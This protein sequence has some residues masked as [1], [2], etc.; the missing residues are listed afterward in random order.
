MTSALCFLPQNPCQ[1]CH[2]N[3]SDKPKLRNILENPDQD[4]LKL[5]RL[6]KK[7]IKEIDMIR[8]DKGDPTTK[9]NV[10]SWILQNKQDID[11]VTSEIQV[12]SL[13]NSIMPL[14]IS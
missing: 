12:C 13:G 10:E 11:A 8:G 5:S 4:S 1:F 2:E 9:C 6:W 3:T 14:L 7:K